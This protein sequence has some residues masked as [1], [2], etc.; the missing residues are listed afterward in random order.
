MGLW[1]I[2]ANPSVATS[3]L[4][5]VCGSPSRRKPRRTKTSYC[6]WPRLGGNWLNGLRLCGNHP[7]TGTPTEDSTVNYLT[8]H[9]TDSKRHGTESLPTHLGFWLGNSSSDTMSHKG[10]NSDPGRTSLEPAVT[11]RKPTALM[12][13]QREALKRNPESELI[14]AGDKRLQPKA[15]AALKPKFETRPPKGRRHRSGPF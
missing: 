9:L 8:V 6:K 11:H 7:L 5:N 4:A 10:R 14:K 2:P 3:T 12:E 15:A 1:R 13:A